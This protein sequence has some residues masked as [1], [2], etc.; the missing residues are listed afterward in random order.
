MTG[1]VIFILIIWLGLGVLTALLFALC[2]DRGPADS[3]GG[4]YIRKQKRGLEQIA[5]KM[6]NLF[7]APLVYVLGFGLFFLVVGALFWLASLLLPPMSM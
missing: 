2:G 3:A 5:Y 7:L 4:R 6:L 1:V